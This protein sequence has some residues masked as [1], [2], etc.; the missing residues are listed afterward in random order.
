[1]YIY[2]ICLFIVEY[3]NGYP[4]SYI[5]SPYIPIILVGLI[6]AQPF[7]APLH[8]LNAS[9]PQHAPCSSA[10]GLRP[11]SGDVALEARASIPPPR[12]T[13]QILCPC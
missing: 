12:R 8:L 6:L 4:I 11:H 5:Q 10:G 13:F 2:V 1:M 9:H 7:L 3:I